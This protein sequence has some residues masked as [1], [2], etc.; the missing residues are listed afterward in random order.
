MMRASSVKIL[1]SKKKEVLH[2][3]FGGNIQNK[4]KHIRHVYVSDGIN[5]QDKEELAAC[6]KFLQTWDYSHFTAEQ[7]GRI[8]LM[9]QVDQA[10][11]DALIIAK[12]FCKEGSKFRALFDNGIKPH[13][14]TAANIFRDKFRVEHPA[15]DEILT[16]PIEQIKLHPSWEALERTV[17]ASD[18]EPM[19][20]YY[21]GKKTIHGSDYDMRGNT[22]VTS[23]LEETD[24]AVN[25]PE[26]LGNKFLDTHH[27]T[28]P[29]IKRDF[30]RAIVQEASDNRGFLRNLFGHPR[31]F[32]GI[33]GDSLY[34]K[35]YAF[36]PQSTVG[37]ITHNCITKT[38]LDIYYVR[39]PV[40]WGVDVLQNGHDSMM[41][42]CYIPFWKDVMPYAMANMQQTLKSKVSSDFMMK[43][44]IGFGFNWGPCSQKFDKVKQEWVLGENPLG[45]L[46]PK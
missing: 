4:D 9:F 38:Q 28:F 10:G 19:R 26:A 3:N 14:Y 17:K 24:G 1:S 16:L 37:V 12:G 20:Y 25:I 44:E 18:N 42:Q 15:V 2:G 43:S 23:I 32:N 36:V 30:H 13:T 27:A 33:W 22:F 11:A 45:L 46:E 35:M 8:K 21:L 41:G 29:E 31:E 34:R 40:E 5:L 39:I 7:L 6:A